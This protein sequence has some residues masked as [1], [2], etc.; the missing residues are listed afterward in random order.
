MGNC[1][2][3]LLFAQGESPIVPPETR[4]DRVV[5][6]LHGGRRR[7][8]CLPEEGGVG[9]AR[10]S[11]GPRGPRLPPAAGRGGELS[12]RLGSGQRDAVLG[13]DGRTAAV[14]GMAWL[15]LA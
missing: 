10:P 15:G 14:L 3:V 8:S 13:Q 12:P 2:Q 1:T 4:G 5:P 9:S 11:Q 7:G 6:A